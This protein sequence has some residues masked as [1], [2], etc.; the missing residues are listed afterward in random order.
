MKAQVLSC[1]ILLALVCALTGP[2]WSADPEVTNVRLKQRP[3][4]SRLVDIFFDV[5]DADGDTLTISLQASANGGATWDFPIKDCSGDVGVGVLSGNDRHII[6]DLK[7]LGIELRGQ[8]RVRVVASDAGVRH[9]RHSP[10]IVAVTDFG[11]VDFSDP[12]VIEKFARADLVQIKGS[13]LWRGGG[14]GDIP[15]ISRM[16]E[17]NPDIK[18]VGYVPSKVTPLFQPSPNEDLFYREWYER[19][20]PFWVST[21]EGDTAQDWY[22]SRLI[23]ILDPECRRVMVSLIQEF[24]TTSL[25]QFDGIYWDYFN[26]RLWI[27][28]N[29]EQDGDP[30]MDGDGIGHWSDPDEIQAFQ[31]AQISLV[32]AVRDSLG[33]DFIQIFNGQRAYS[34]STFAALA[35]GVMYEL[36]P[37]LFFPD[38]DMATAMDPSFTYSL[39]SMQRWLRSDNGGPFIIIE[40]KNSTHYTDDQGLPQEIYSGNKYRALAL[41]L[42]GVYSS[43]NSHEGSTGI[44]TYGWP[45]VEISLGQP[46]GPVV[47]DG[48]FMRR[49][50]EYGRVEVDMSRGAYPNSMDYWI[51][52]L[53]RV[54]EALDIPY[55]VP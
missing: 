34:D 28:W 44:H 22:T 27:P 16:K 25:N 52:E 32:N 30:D 21:T 33:Q 10:A 47:F 43:W 51:W 8:H 5:A 54:V 37:T 7:P 1:G 50:Y 36:F 29:L 11:N 38:P 4:G 12:G 24:Q 23:N 55:H 46:L 20:S 17:L 49:E 41:L 35:D 48:N 18:V 39:F 13:S 14:N 3:D 6:W 9:E 2:V 31:D 53:G 19:T 45:D 40:N 15:V 42:D 26:T